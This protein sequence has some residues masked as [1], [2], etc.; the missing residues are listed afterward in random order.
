M[1]LPSQFHTHCQ[2]PQGK[3]PNQNLSKSMQSKRTMDIEK[4]TPNE[5]TRKPNKMYSECTFESFSSSLQ[6]DTLVRMESVKCTH[7]T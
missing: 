6:F 2:V 4:T 3:R 1:R 7:H 5:K